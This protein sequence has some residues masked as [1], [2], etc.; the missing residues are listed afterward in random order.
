MLD[1]FLPQC[2]AD[3]R[4][5][6]TA[7]VALQELGLPYA[8][9]PAITRHVAAFLSVHSQAGPPDAILLNGG[10]FNSARIASRLVEVVSSWYSN[11]TPIRLLK[12]DSLELAVARG[13]AYY[14]L[15]RRGM[16]RRI[17]G[18]TAHAF[19]V[20]LESKREPKAL[21]VIPRGHE[22]GRTVE[23]S[24]RTF[25]LTLGRP[26]QFPLFTSTS[27][28]VASSGEIVTI[29]DDLHALPPIHTVLISNESQT[30]AVPVHIR[31]TLTE[32]G[33]LE[34]WCVSENANEQWRLEFE[35]RGTGTAAR[36]TVIESMPPRFA[37]ART[38]IEHIFGGKPTPGSP[39]T[40]EIK[41]LWRGLEQTLGPRET[42]ARTRA[43]RMYG[44]RCLP[45]R[46]VDDA[47]PITSGSGFNSAVIRCGPVSVIPWT[48]GAQNRPQR[49]LLPESTHIKRNASGRNSGSCGDELPVD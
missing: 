18:G 6:R 3:E 39:I 4:P 42:M 47:R 24:A 35:L 12:H 40:T 20:G 33:T 36:E 19:Y 26:V 27:D 37:E 16:G 14:G 28:R 15:V 25:N 1:G 13:A 45:A 5:Q 44:V 49:C 31:A 8:Q 11:S 48:N 7:R 10:V 38:S 34:L 46:V 23:I 32:I 2:A 41:Q 43:P 9:D 29:E 30:G 17:G 22:E 21:C